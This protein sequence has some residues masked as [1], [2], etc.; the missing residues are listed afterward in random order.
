MLV[1]I[2]VGVIYK[3][4]LLCEVPVLRVCAA[5]KYSCKQVVC[6]LVHDC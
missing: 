6:D 2:G 3:E 4:L 1:R 5:C